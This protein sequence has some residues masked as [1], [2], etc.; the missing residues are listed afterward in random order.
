[1]TPPASWRAM[2]A[3]ALIRFVAAEPGNFLSPSWDGPKMYVNI[4][5]VK[6]ARVSKVSPGF[7][8]VMESLQGD[9][10]QGRLH[11]GKA[12]RPGAEAGM[13]G[14]SKARAQ[15]HTGRVGAISGAPLWP[16]IPLEISEGSGTAGTSGSLTHL[17][18]AACFVPGD[19]GCV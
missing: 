8:A 6:Y 10:C 1:M 2:R 4:D 11:W 13:T 5:Y 16:W 15:E 9:T 17:S 3:P 7:D 14:A 19:A 12:A 18:G